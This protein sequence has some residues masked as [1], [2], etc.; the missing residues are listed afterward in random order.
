MGTLSLGAVQIIPSAV[1]ASLPMCTS[2]VGASCVC[3]RELASSRDLPGQT[4]RMSLVG[5]WRP[6]CS[7]VG[8]DV[9]GA[10]FPPFPSPLPPASGG[11]WAS[12]LQA[13][14][15]LELLSPFVLQMAGSVFR[16]VNFLSLSCYPTV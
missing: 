6:V 13:S 11:G 5:N 15:S 2:L 8:G 12:P 14:S 7:L 3:S 16:P 1:P 9:S 4:L 10:E